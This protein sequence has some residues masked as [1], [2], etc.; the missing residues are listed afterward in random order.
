MKKY[1]NNNHIYTKSIDYL[2]TGE[3]GSKYFS[4]NQNYDTVVFDEYYNISIS[5]AEL[6][7]YISDIIRGYNKNPTDY[8]FISLLDTAIFKDITNIQ[9]GQ[10]GNLEDPSY[11]YYTNGLPKLVDYDSNE[12][13]GIVPSM[14]GII[15]KEFSISA[16]SIQYNNTKSVV[17]QEYILMS[18]PNQYNATQ[19][20]TWTPG[21]PFYVNTI[22][23]YDN[24]GEIVS[25]SQISKSIR[26]D[27]KEPLNI[28]ITI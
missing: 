27:K 28:K 20:D 26:F 19:N 3:S 12:T 7:I 1:E 10:P 13:I 14:A 6:N 23:T 5:P 9:V 21:D 24:S 11:F 17:A 2:D 25:V 22:Y 4:F 8:F 16:I 15:V 18:R